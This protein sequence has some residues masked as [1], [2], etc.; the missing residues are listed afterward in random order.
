MSA[1]IEV[2]GTRLRS[3]RFWQENGTLAVL[4][5]FVVFATVVSEGVFIRPSNLITILYQASIV[6]VLVL[7]QS[8]VVIAG[9]LDLSI[10]AVLILSATVMGG[11]GSEQQSM[12]MLGGLPYIGLW[13]AVFAGFLTAAFFGLV[14]GLMVTALRIPAFISTLATTLLVGGIILVVTGGSPIY[15]PDPFFTN[16]G[17]AKLFDLPAP[18]YVFFGLAAVVWWLLNHTSFGRKLYAVG[19]SERASHYSGLSVFGMRLAVFVLCG[20]CAGLAGFLFLSR[21]G[22][23]SYASGADLL[24]TTIASLVVGGISL[25]GGVGGVKHAVSGVLLLA[26]LSNFM[27]IMLIS[28]HIQ[29]AVNGFVILI[30][31]STYSYINSEKA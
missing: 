10:V 18:V 24:M 23:I 28:P 25:A 17:N 11:A 6:G 16:F 26:A 2:A 5:V 9:G 15:Y 3:P 31:V 19:G 30:A 12:M 14:N 4:L 20:L 8:L 22:Y 1:L 13:P 29:D 21:T 27:N 7:G